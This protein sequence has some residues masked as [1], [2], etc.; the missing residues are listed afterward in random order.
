M[1]VV[2]TIKSLKQELEKYNSKNVGFV[3]TMGALH[4]GHISLV[5]RSVEENDVTV[6]SVFVN[7]TQFNDK[8]DLERYPRTEEADKKL[9]EA[10][11]CDIVF[12]PQVEEMYPE[13]DTRV[14]N[15][16]SIETVMEGKYRPGHFNGV[17][18]IVSKLFYAVEPTRSYFGE[19]DF[20]Q[21]AIIRDMVKQLNIPVEIIACPIIREES[22]LARS[23][24][25]E[26]LSAEERKKAALISQ[27]L[28]KSVNFAK[29][30]SVEEVKNWVNDQFKSDDT[31]KMDYYDIVDGNSLQSVSSWDES[32]YIVGCIA[33]Y[34]GKIRLID[35]IHY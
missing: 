6:V 22:G 9:L 8:A 28:S 20:Q 31:F 34:C 17:A 1:I 2:E 16:G 21:V 25:N 14:F 32:D 26:L 35:N 29:D 10:A 30:M 5:K 33:I 13:E 12:M 23:S 15:F 18:Q 11:G 7:P 4:D 27:V 19:K 3:P 24:R